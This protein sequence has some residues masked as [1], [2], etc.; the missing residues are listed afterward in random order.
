MESR[1]EGDVTVVYP[2]GFINAH[3][4]R[5]FEQELNVAL[6]SGQVKIVIN[7]S[8]LSY[9]A[10]AGTGE[11]VSHTTIHRPPDPSFATPYVV[12]DV[13]MDEGWRLLTWI[14]DTDPNNVS[15]GM[16]VEVCFVAGPD[17]D[18]LPAFVNRS[19]LTK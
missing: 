16:R 17:G 9:V 7:G 18:T 11:V 12:A 6:E 10:S 15:I 3:T 5:Q 13:Q 1:Q 14:V 19:G 2:R 8:G 4:V